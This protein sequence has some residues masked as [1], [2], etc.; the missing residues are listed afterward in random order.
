MTLEFQVDE[1]AGIVYWTSVGADTEEEWDKV[2][3]EVID[4]YYSAPYLSTLVD[5][6]DHE[7]TLSSEYIRKVI[8]RIPPSLGDDRPKWAFVVKGELKFGLARMAATHL[9][10]KGFQAKVFTDYNLAVG[11]LEDH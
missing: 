3:G 9:E 6:R 5:H 1:Q 8:S 4:N 2:S 10:L 7:P 11:W